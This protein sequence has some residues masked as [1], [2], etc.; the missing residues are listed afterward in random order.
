MLLQKSLL[1]NW[2]F[3]FLISS[4]KNNSYNLMKQYKIYGKVTVYLIWDHLQIIIIDIH[5]K[6]CWETFSKLAIFID[7]Q[8][9]SPKQPL[10]RP[11]Q[12]D[13]PSTKMDYWSTAQ[14]SPS[15]NKKISKHMSSKLSKVISELPTSRVLLIW[16]RRKQ[17]QQSRWSWLGLT[18][19]NRTG[20]AS[21][22][23]LR[24]Y[25]FSWNPPIFHQR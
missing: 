25:N 3:I 22:I 24:L 13:S 14:A 5:I 17:K 4:S 6:K 20:N 8:A 9:K 7:S 1:K 18:R 19:R 11:Q 16:Y 23:G 15:R 12:L 10:R 2:C 21:R